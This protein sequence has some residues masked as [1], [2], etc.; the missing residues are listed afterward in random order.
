MKGGR[1][2]GGRDRGRKRK[3]MNEEL[4]KVVLSSSAFLH[5]ERPLGPLCLSVGTCAISKLND[6]IN[7]SHLFPGVL[8]KAVHK[9]VTT[10]NYLVCS[11]PLLHHQ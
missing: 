5:C 10:L 11:G 7:A 9:S 4:Q 6:W 2:R 8:G 1:K 3:R